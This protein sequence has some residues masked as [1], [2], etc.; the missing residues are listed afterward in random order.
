ML[1]KFIM[2]ANINL[3]IIGLIAIGILIALLVKL[4]SSK[5]PKRK[6]NVELVEANK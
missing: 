4:K 3:I 2:I 5:S 6:I 1:Y